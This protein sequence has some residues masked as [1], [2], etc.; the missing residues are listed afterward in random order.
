MK[1]ILTLTALSFVSLFGLTR[2]IDGIPDEGKAIATVNGKKITVAQYVNE[3]FQQIK[4]ISKMTQKPFTMQDAVK[5]GMLPDQLHR[6]VSESV[7]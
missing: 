6:L 3:V 7:T 5:T 4:A 1:G 2:T